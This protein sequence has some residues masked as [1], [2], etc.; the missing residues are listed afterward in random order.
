MDLIEARMV[1]YYG[2][3]RLEALERLLYP[4]TPSAERWNPESW[5]TGPEAA[6]GQQAMME[7]L[8]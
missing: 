7:M 2:P 5:G 4:D 1:D 8:G 6:A 3:E